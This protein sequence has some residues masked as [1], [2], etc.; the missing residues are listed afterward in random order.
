MAPRPQQGD[1]LTDALPSALPPIFDQAQNTTANHRKNIVQLRKIH[2]T[3][4]NITEET[5]KGIRL[6]GER[7]FNNAF[8]GMVNRVLPVKKGVAVADRV[9]KFVAS[10]VA[11]TTENGGFDGVGADWQRLKRMMATAWHPALQPSCSSTSL[12]AWR[13]R[14]RMCASVL[15]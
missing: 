8:V 15:L 7:A 14:T 6:I 3:C 4:A 11:Y 10:Y 9:V 12:R 13:P 1:Y 2:E 5:P